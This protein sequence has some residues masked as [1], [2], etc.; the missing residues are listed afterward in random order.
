[1]TYLWDDLVSQ[2]L[3]IQKRLKNDQNF[4]KNLKI[5]YERDLRKATSLFKKIDKLNLQSLSLKELSRIGNE[6]SHAI[7]LAVGVAHMIEPYAIAGDQRI[8]GEVQRHIKDPAL[9]NMIFLSLTTPRTRSFVSQ[10]ES[11]I[12]RLAG[13]EVIMDRE[14][15][16]Y[17]KKFFWVENTYSGRRNPSIDDVRLMVE[18]YRQQ[19]KNTLQEHFR[20]MSQ[21]RVRHSSL[22]Q[23]LL[24]ELRMFAFLSIW[25]DERKRNILIGIDYLERVLEVIAQKSGIPILLL[26]YLS[27]RELASDFST[28]SSVLEKRREGIV[29]LQ[30]KNGIEVGTYEDFKRFS[31]SMSVEKNVHETEL[32][33]TSASVGKVIG[34][35]KVCPNPD[36]IKKVEEGDI[37]VASMTRPEYLPAMRRAAAFVTDEGGITC[38]AAIVA[39]EMGK[40]CVIGTR[41]ATRFLKD[42]DLVEVKG[43][44]G[45]V[46][47]IEKSI[48]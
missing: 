2:D 4:Y 13:Q 26:R 40:P 38:H 32:R 44:H 23:F 36:S 37:L 3:V 29:F 5:R 43:N 24:F 48:R 1:M 35:V 41:F 14:L 22:P 10:A 45:V 33:G 47:V 20:P 19:K 11:Y 27:P 6:A 34:R 39:R 8:R 31:A 7:A 9:A 21:T 42:G 17:I 46:I 18:E 30:T 12:A 28:M 16:G 15:T 25:Q